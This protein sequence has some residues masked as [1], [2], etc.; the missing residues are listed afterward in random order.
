[1]AKVAVALQVTIQAFARPLGTRL[2]VHLHQPVADPCVRQEP[3]IFAGTA[4]QL[5]RHAGAYVVF[6]GRQV[7]CAGNHWHG[8]AVEAEREAVGVAVDIG[9]RELDQ[10][11]AR[12]VVRAFVKAIRRR[13][14]QDRD[15]QPDPV[16]QL[17]AV[18]HGQPEVA[19]FAGVE[20]Y[21]HHF[22]WLGLVEVLVLLGPQQ[23][24]RHHAVVEL[25]EFAG[26][27]AIR[28]ETQGEIHE[29]NSG[30]A[31][32]RDRFFELGDFGQHLLR[33]SCD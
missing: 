11:H 18:F 4:R 2:G 30:I 20:L 13:E 16:Q 31:D 25:D 19:L 14:T 3:A 12:P 24:C 23:A 6:V 26:L 7:R 27:L 17:Q 1:M 9:L 10:A 32:Q 5:E 29:L 28:A 21:L 33:F 22:V 8:A 15:R